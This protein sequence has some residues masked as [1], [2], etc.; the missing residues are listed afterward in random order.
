M[1]RTNPSAKNLGQKK[2]V[3]FSNGEMRG[4]KNGERES[5]WL[6]NNLGTEGIGTEEEFF[7][8]K[9]GKKK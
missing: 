2:V 6:R 9:E 4:K 7:D 1:E 8:E 5:S 3:I